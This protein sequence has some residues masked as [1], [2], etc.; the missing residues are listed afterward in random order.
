MTGVVEDNFVDHF[1]VCQRPKR[2][3]FFAFVAF[4]G[5]WGISRHP[6]YLGENLHWWSHYVFALAATGQQLHFCSS[7]NVPSH[8]RF[9]LVIVR[10]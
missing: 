2:L 10:G 9:F 4:A 1:A 7:F 8:M 6:N 5:L 3:L